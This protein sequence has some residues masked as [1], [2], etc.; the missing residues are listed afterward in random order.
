MKTPIGR[1]IYQMVSA[2]NTYVQEDVVSGLGS[3]AV[4]KRAGIVQL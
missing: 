2:L 1:G 3:M 4:F